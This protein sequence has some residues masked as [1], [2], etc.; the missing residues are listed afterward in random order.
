MF[1]IRVLVNIIQELI[2][3][4]YRYIMSIVRKIASKLFSFQL[5]ILYC[6]DIGKIKLLK[7]SIPVEYK[8]GTIKDLIRLDSKKYDCDKKSID[9]LSHCLRCGDILIIG[10]INNEIV[11]YSWICF[12]KLQLD[13]NRFAKLNDDMATIYKVFTCEEHRGNN[14]YP[15]SY[16]FILRLMKERGVNFIVTCIND[17]NISSRRSAKKIGFKKQGYYFSW[18]LLGIR[19]F[20]LIDLLKIFLLKKYLMLN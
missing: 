3:N 2:L 1:R 15:S 9:Y 8:E 18:N 13:I 11:F 12:G 19:Y 20:R 5:L 4:I 16:N 7:T 6:I 17:T 14:I 10:E